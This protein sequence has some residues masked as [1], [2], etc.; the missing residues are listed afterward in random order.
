MNKLLYIFLIGF[1]LAASCNPDDDQVN[2]IEP[3]TTFRCKVNGQDWTPAGGTSQ[4]IYPFDL[5]YYSDTGGLE[6][7]A[8][9]IILSE[10]VDQGFHL[11]SRIKTLNT[12]TPFRFEEEV[13]L[14]NF[15]SLNCQRFDLDST[16]N[17]Y[18]KL[19]TI[20]STSFFIVGE[21]EFSA[22]TECEHF[23][24]VTEGYFD[25]KYTF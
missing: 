19:N 13:F 8:H 22:I 20:D 7:L 21:F 24:Q 18:I 17:N 12:D 11:V 5:Q 2:E 9:R 4:T 23:I 10:N 25:L 16:S 1:L 3:H 15:N 14:D 6:L